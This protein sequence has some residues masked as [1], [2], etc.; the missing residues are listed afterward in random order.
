[1]N[2]QEPFRTH[3]IDF[4]N[5]V[6]TPKHKT[7]DIKKIIFIKYNDKVNDKKSNLK[8]FVIQLPSLLNLNEPVKITE[9]YYELEIP[10]ITQEKA[11][12]LPLIKFFE[13]LDTK[14]KNDAKFNSNS[15]FENISNT[16]IKH[17]KLIK[18]SDL[19][20]EGILKIKI[21]K[22]N[23][24]ETLL[25]INNKRKLII[26]EIPSDS[27]CKILIEVYAVVINSQKGEFS[28]FLRPIILSF[29]EKEII[30]YNY[31]FLED[32]NSESED[33]IPDSELNSI[34]IKNIK[35]EKMKDDNNTSSQIKVP[36]KN[37]SS[38]EF[39]STSSSPEIT[40][41]IPESELEFKLEHESKPELESKLELE[42]KPE[43]ESKAETENT[44]ESK[45]ELEIIVESE[46]SISS[47]ENTEE[48]INKLKK[49]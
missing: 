6:Y 26:S 47:D 41:N 14:I 18:E 46:S 44:S 3:Q 36:M 35:D 8:P 37:T 7:S 39:S 28:I 30:N 20:K 24:F 19:Y 21:I 4:N 17:K 22:N 48:I 13:D 49:L 12:N 10:L 5:I 2:F 27:W 16:S 40:K 34:F 31:K 33:D 15:W 25:Q 1:M 23:S 32:S 38:S 11:K 9:D 45:P 29:K 42:S 43:L